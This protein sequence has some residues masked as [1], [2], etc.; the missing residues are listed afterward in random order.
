MFADEMYAEARAA[1]ERS[2]QGASKEQREEINRWIEACRG[3]VEF[4]KVDELMNQK[5]WQKALKEQ[6]RL[7][8]K[9]SAT[10]LAPRL[11]EA[12]AKI[13]DHLFYYVATFEEDPPEPEKAL[14]P[15]PKSR[16]LNEDSRYVR[17]GKRSIM[18]RITAGS[19]R[20]ERYQRLGQVDGSKLDQC[21]TLK[22]SIF[23]PAS[24]GS[25][26]LLLVMARN[27]DEVKTKGERFVG[28][29]LH[30]VL[31]ADKGGWNDVSID[32]SKLS[33][34]GDFAM[35]EVKE[36]G[37]IVL[38]TNTDVVYFDEVFFVRR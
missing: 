17:R 21:S 1:F 20:S 12:Y 9:Y 27:M 18:W 8:E 30:Y 35:N 36:M 15:L 19:D 3:G 4:A 5:N 32:L 34:S 23:Y 25:I 7:E 38:G 11:A 24:R 14:Y 29:G 33:N 26:K 22:L 28:E 10:A 37:V 16:S 13:S 2:R 6:Q 31:I